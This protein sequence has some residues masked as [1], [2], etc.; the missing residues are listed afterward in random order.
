MSC[1]RWSRMKEKHLE[2]GPSEITGFLPLTEDYFGNLSLFESTSDRVRLLSDNFVRDTFH[3]NYK[4]ISKE[5]WIENSCAQNDDSGI[6]SSE[7]IA[8][9]CLLS[10]S[11]FIYLFRVATAALVWCCFSCRRKK[12]K[13]GKSQTL[14]VVYIKG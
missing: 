1:N 8:E 5:R 10:S 11:L 13:L 6:L 3:V 14:F 12:P 4:S 2:G 7:G 9:D